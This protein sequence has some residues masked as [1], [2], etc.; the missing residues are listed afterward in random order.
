MS[1]PLP[2]QSNFIAIGAWNPAIIQP[3]WLKKEFPDLIPEEK[4]P[5]QIV[6]GSISSFRME[7]DKFLLDPSGGRLIFIPIKLDD[8]T[9]ELIAQLAKEIREKLIFT[10]ISASGCNFAFKLEENESFTIDEFE[11][12][13][14]IKELYGSLDKSCEFISRGIRN[15]FSAEDHSINITYE[16]KGKEKTLR[17]N[18]EYKQPSDSMLVAAKAFVENYHH[19]LKL[20][21]TLI[22]NN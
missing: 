10:P 5:I 22:R 8:P 19:S 13:D 20:I 9:L 4:I 14:K 6:T 16:Y 12:I 15:S 1:I 18:Y 7:Y 11:Q 2:D 21:D 17:L 3:A